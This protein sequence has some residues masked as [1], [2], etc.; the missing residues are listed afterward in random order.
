MER[1][2]YIG[3]FNL[4]FLLTFV[5]FAHVSHVAGLDV[6]CHDACVKWWTKQWQVWR[7]DGAGRSVS[8]GLC[9]IL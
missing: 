1:W 8:I 4:H 6:V 7:H 3:D 9:M 2:P 5:V